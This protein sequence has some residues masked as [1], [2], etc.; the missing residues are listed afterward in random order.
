LTAVAK[1]QIP[2]I[3][4]KNLQLRGPGVLIINNAKKVDATRYTCYFSYKVNNVVQKSIVKALR[5]NFSGAF[6]EKSNAIVISCLLFLLY[7]LPK[8]LF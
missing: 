1:R 7:M 3:I 4:L 2:G 5:V 8:K 6:V